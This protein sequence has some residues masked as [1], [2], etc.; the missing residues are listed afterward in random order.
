V[1]SVRLLQLRDGIDDNTLLTQ[2]ARLE[3]ARANAIAAKI[4]RSA[5]D[6]ETDPATW[7]EVRRELLDALDA[8]MARK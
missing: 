2:L 1:P 7:L 8:A 6:F 3:P 5:D 4:V